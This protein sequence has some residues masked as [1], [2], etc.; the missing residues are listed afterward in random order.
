M[1]LLGHADDW[2]E[3]KEMDYIGENLYFKNIYVA[4]SHAATIMSDMLLLD[5]LISYI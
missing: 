5:M 3:N 1:L 2:T 4:N